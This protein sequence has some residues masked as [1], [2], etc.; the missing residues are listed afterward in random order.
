MNIINF[1]YTLNIVGLTFDM[2]GAVLV[3]WEVSRQ[4]KGKKFYD[5]GQAQCSTITYSPETEE[6]KKYTNNKE[7]KMKLGLIFLLIGF[8]I[9]IISNIFSLN[10]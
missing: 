3:A 6:F 10:N 9:Q 2:L 1:S 7:R 8:S 4:F 5:V